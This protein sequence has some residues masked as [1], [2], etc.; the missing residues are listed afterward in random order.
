MVAVIDGRLLQRNR[1]VQAVMESKQSVESERK[2]VEIK[3]SLAPPRR[4]AERERMDTGMSSSG[5]LKATKKGSKK[6]GVFDGGAT[7]DS[8]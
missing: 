1:N 8:V 3:S 4:A 6:A 2:K 7:T 5:R